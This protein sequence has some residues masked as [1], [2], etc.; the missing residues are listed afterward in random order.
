MSQ[1]EADRVHKLGLRRYADLKEHLLHFTAGLVISGVMLAGAVGGPDLAYPFAL[2][3]GA[4][5]FYMQLLQMGV[6]A[7]P[8][9]MR[10][11]QATASVS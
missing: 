10:Y 3:G 2:G 5:F 8:G 11:C 9:G 7:L 1:E 4:G 6:D